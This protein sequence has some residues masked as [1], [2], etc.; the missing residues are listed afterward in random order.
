MRFSCLQLDLE[1]IAK[2]RRQGRDHQSGAPLGVKAA[3]PLQMPSEVALGHK[4][5]DNRLR[6]ARIR[7]PNRF[8]SFVGLRRD[9]QV[10]GAG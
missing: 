3:H 10:L 8:R 7:N 5:S 6:R 9:G 1:P 2:T 4:S